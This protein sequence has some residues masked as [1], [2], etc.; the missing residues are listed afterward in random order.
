MFKSGSEEG[1]YIAIGYFLSPSLLITDL[2][3]YNSCTIQFTYFKCA[4]QRFL[5]QP[6]SCTSITTVSFRTFP[7]TQCPCQ[8][9]FLI[10]SQTSPSPRQTQVYFLS[11]WIC[12]LW[13][14]HINEIICGL[15]APF[16]LAYIFRACPCCS[17]Y[18]CLSPSHC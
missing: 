15:L 17:I 13:T 9:S 18:Q 1:S 7:I 8:Q 5:V 12:L 10:S 4:M 6:H 3:R 16:A 2:L 14:F 11:L